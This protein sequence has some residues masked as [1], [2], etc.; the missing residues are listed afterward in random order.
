MPPKKF[1]INNWEDTIIYTKNKESNE[2]EAYLVWTLKNNCINYK[3]YMDSNIRKK[4]KGINI[5]DEWFEE[6]KKEDIRRIKR[7]N[8]LKDFIPSKFIPYWMLDNW[9]RA[10]CHNTYDD[11]INAKEDVYLK[12]LSA[13]QTAAIASRLYG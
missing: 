4:I 5:I 10:R 13:Q 8:I 9:I 6:A 11:W 1:N 3:D 2:Y 12:L 7:H